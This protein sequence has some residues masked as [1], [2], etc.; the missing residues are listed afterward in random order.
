MYGV[1]GIWGLAVKRP[2]A[3]LADYMR[4]ARAE[5]RTF[6]DAWADG[7]VLVTRG[8]LD[9][10]EYMQALSATRGAWERAYEGRPA[11]DADHAA[12]LL[13]DA[14]LGDVEGVPDRPCDVCGADL[15]ALG[16]SVQARYCGK[17]CQKLAALAREREARA[18]TTP[19][20]TPSPP[21]LAGGVGTR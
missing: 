9:G 20:R 19:S 18:Y 4:R 11:T 1:P 21:V 5:G 12:A 15:D 7:V 2:T 6:W 8:R 14:A 10:G 16:R 3:E 17:D 13:A